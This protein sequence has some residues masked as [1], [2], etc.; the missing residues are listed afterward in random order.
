MTDWSAV[1]AVATGAGALV[2]GITG[3]L[4]AW[5]AWETRK[6][7]QAGR[8]AVAVGRQG[9]D[10][11]RHT[12]AI[13]RDSQQAAFDSIEIGRADVEVARDSLAIS[14]RMA[15]DSTKARLDNRA[16]KLL[17]L[18]TD[19]D[20]DVRGKSDV[21][22]DQKWPTD[23]EL[24]RTRDD[25]VRLSVGAVFRIVNEGDRS[26]LV[27]VQG[28]VDYFRAIGPRFNRVDGELHTWLNPEQ[29]CVFRLRSSRPLQEWAEIWQAR[30]QGLSDPAC[31]NGTIICSDPYDEGVVDRWDI[32]FHG[33]PVESRL[34]DVAAWV[35][36]TGETDPP[37]VRATVYPQER[38]YFVSKRRNLRLED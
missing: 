25:N 30:Q 27:R 34:G 5:Q 19:T 12:L 21:G 31:T 11:A 37:V 16:P 13:S 7:A 10:V 35:V 9:V 32:Q 33:Y 17:V 4:I 38:E 8:D 1:G 23:A 20:S 36:R 22:Q 28:D 15:I 18:A 24:R 6:T 29:S 2:T 14:R 26:V 3:G